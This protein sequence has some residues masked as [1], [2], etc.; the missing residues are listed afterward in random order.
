MSRTRTLAISVAVSIVGGLGLLGH[1]PASASGRSRHVRAEFTAI[2]DPPTSGAP[3]CDPSGRCLV[4]YSIPS[5]T[6]SGDVNGSSVTNGVVYLDPVTLAST[7]SSYQLFTGSIDR[8]GAGT[9]VIVLPQFTGGP[10]EPIVASGT[11]VPGSGTGE[12][13][14]ISG[15]V[16]STFVTDSTGGGSATG[17]F[18]VRCE[19]RQG[20]RSTHEA[21]PAPSR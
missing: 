2:S 13:A 5:A 8:C 4:P 19:R 7:G 11:V 6:Y 3:T 10:A 14:G 17:R 15:R 21:A 18:D 1:V 9:L 16:T 20:A 12:L